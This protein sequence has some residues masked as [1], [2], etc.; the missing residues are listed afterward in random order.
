MLLE[1]Q[2]LLQHYGEIENSFGREPGR[3]RGAYM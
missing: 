1:R 2:P 3:D